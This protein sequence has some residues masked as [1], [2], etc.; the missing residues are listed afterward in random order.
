MD[1]TVWAWIV[2]W[3]DTQR[4][5]QLKA[6]LEEMAEH[7]AR[8][9][10]NEEK[11]SYDNVVLVLMK[12]FV[13]LTLLDWSFTNWCKLGRVWRNWVR[14]FR[15][16][17]IKHFERVEQRNLIG[18]W[19]E[20]S[21]KHSCREN[22]GTKSNWYVWALERHEQQFAPARGASRQKEQC[23]GKTTDETPLSQQVLQP[24]LMR[25]C[26]Q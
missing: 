25:L 4:L 18:L 9:I 19:R 20:G 26:K 14:S 13:Q 6:H 22:W 2:G 11:A 3:S 12:R 21:I 23:I 17:D 16:W 1:K 8:M 5:F 7:T 10:P 24:P 15:S